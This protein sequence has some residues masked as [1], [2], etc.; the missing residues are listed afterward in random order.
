MITKYEQLTI[1]YYDEEN[2]EYVEETFKNST[3]AFD[4][5]YTSIIGKKRDFTIKTSLVKNIDG[6]GKYYEAPPQH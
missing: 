4:Q 6:R 2:E 1:V 3:Y 5:V